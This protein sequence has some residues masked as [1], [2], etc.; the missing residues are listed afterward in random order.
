MKTKEELRQYKREYRKKN[1][2]KEKEKA[3]AYR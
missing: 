3:A 1:A 2:E